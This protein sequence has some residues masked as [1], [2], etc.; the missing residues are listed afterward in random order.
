MGQTKFLQCAVRLWELRRHTCAAAGLWCSATR[1]AGRRQPRGEGRQGRPAHGQ[2]P[3]VCEPAKSVSL[4]HCI[5]SCACANVTGTT[6]AGSTD[7][8]LWTH[9][10]NGARQYCGNSF[11]D[12]MRKN[13][14]LAQ[15]PA[16]T[17]ALS[18]LVHGAGIGTV[19]AAA[20]VL[21][22]RPLA[23]LPA[24]PKPTPRRT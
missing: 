24:M 1:A 11:P 2:L 23:A 21:Q 16:C 22:R 14:R 8:S 6:N 3:V 4:L 19:P 12:G 7:T 9:Y 18:A 5:I 17:L 13:D 20:H 10:K 15:V